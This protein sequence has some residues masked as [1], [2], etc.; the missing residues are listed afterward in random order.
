M[1]LVRVR[2]VQESKRWC[3]WKRQQGRW[4]GKKSVKNKMTDM[5]V[6]YFQV[7]E[8]AVANFQSSHLQIKGLTLLWMC[9]CCL[10]PDE[11]AN[12]LPHSGHVWARAP[13]C[14][15]R[16]WRWRLLGSVKTWKVETSIWKYNVL[17][18]PKKERKKKRKSPVCI[19]FYHS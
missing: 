1:I 8:K 4:G 5:N 6:F 17:T 19:T 3:R 10:R 7:K 2:S 9:L 13:T 12:V 18:I 14:W 15:E 16:M 11:V